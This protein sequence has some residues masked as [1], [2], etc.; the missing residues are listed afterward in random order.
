LISFFRP[1]GRSFFF[2]KGFLICAYLFLMDAQGT[3]KVR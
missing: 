3:K 1:S 2:L